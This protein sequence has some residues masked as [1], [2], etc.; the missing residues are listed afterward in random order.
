MHILER[1]STFT[2]KRHLMEIPISAEEFN[3]R[4]D[5]WRRGGLI[6]DCFPM[7]TA[8][9]REFIITGMSEEEQDFVFAEEDE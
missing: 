4:H 5:A 3:E 6:Q 9:Q 8:V 7:L 1:V 2:G